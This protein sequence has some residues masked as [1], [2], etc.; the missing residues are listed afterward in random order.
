MTN[1]ALYPVAVITI[2]SLITFGLRAFPFLIFGNRPL[3]ESIQ[4]LGR[5]LPSAIMT[6][7]VIYCLRDTSF[8]Q[9]PF[10]LP[11]IVASF[12]VII[13]QITRKNMYLSIV[14]GTLIY[15]LLL[16]LL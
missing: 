3:P 1:S 12:S 11:E 8:T 14:A 7:L 5:V 13:L 2:V 10:G 16:R 15:M 6:V 9:Y 4:Y